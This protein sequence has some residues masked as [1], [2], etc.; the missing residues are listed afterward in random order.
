MTIADLHNKRIAILGLGVNNQQ[1]ALYLL[2]QGL[3]VTI[4]DKKPEVEKEFRQA[5]P[6]LQEKITWEIGEDVLKNLETFEVVFRSPS[7]PFLNPKIQ[8]AMKKGVIIYS[9]TKL[10]FDLSPAPIVAVSGTNG[11]GTTTTL[12][13]KMLE[14]GYKEGK[15]YMGG[16][17]GLDPFSFLPQLTENDV[18]VLELSSFQLQD[19]HVSPHIA[20][21]LSMTP[22][23]LDH[24]QTLEEY[25]G[26]K[27]SLVRFQGPDDI[28]IV[29]ADNQVSMS[30]ARGIKSRILRY[31]R[32]RPQ[33]QAA[34][35]DSGPDHENAFL[36]VDDHLESFSLLGRRLIGAHNLENILAASLVAYSCGVPIPTIQKVATTF[37]GLAHRLSFVL[38]VD[39]VD[40]YDD[41]ISTSPAT[42]EA[43]LDAF[44]GRRVHLIA[45]G[46][47]KGHDFSDLAPVLVQS[48]TTVSLLPGEATKKLEK[49]LQRANREVAADKRLLI[50]NKAQPP[51]FPTILSGIHPHLKSGDVV[52]LSPAAA[53]FASFTN[54]KARGDAFIQA[55]SERYLTPSS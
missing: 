52:L 9:Q 13:S 41:S 35:V 29:H 38:S 25:Y 51:L 40:F 44:S 32:S 36:Q 26:A 7:I 17:I 15:T 21:L 14:A 46:S 28:A 4:R 55:V 8:K 1:L 37:A 24:H 45:G 20:V 50:L 53:S 34:W 33:R 27:S 23:H 3:S 18:V 42:C 30:L 43:A 48:C 22:D 19:L 5:H 47:D 6:A 12:I 39:G 2:E 49:A 54:Y 16:N 11:K 31:T 10:F